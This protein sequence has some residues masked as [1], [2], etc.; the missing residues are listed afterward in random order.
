MSYKA[1]VRLAKEFVLAVNGMVI[2]R[3]TDFSLSIDKE[4][5]DITS[6][7]S[8]GFNEVLGG[9]KSWN[10]SFGSMV[11][12]EYGSGAPTGVQGSGVFD[13]LF[14]HLISTEADY[15]VTVGLGD[16]NGGTASYE[17]LGILSNLSLDGA[18]GDKITY[19]GTIEGSGKLARV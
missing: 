3:C 16:P 2:A 17:G 14:D 19:S 8:E 13:N 5:I 4:T 18:V 12:R 11:T 15:P 7:D 1:I 10:I 6:F 9:Q